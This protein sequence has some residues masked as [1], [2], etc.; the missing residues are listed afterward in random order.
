MKTKKLTKEAKK[1]LNDAGFCDTWVGTMRKNAEKE[2]NT[3]AD[4]FTH[5]M[6]KGG[7]VYNIGM[8]DTIRD[9]QWLYNKLAAYTLAER[10]IKVDIT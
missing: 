8:L 4:E 3:K 2:F 10:E 6:Q 7:G 9:L 5:L 1:R